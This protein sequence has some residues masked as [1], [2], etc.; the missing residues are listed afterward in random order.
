MQFPDVGGP[1]NLGVTAKSGWVIWSAATAPK[2][3]LNARSPHA[4]LLLR[5]TQINQEVFL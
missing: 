4:N 5:L 2:K 3:E 1:A